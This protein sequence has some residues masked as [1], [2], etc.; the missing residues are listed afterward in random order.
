MKVLMHLK[1]LC[2]WNFGI[3]LQNIYIAYKSDSNLLRNWE[4]HKVWELKVKEGHTLQASAAFKITTIQNFKSRKI[5]WFICLGI[6]QTHQYF[7]KK[8]I[9]LI[10]VEKIWKSIR[11]PKWL[12]MLLF[13]SRIRETSLNLELFTFV[14]IRK[15][16]KK[17]ISWAAGT[18]G[19]P[20]L[21]FGG[22][23]FDCRTFQPQSFFNPKIQAQTFNPRLFNHKLGAKLYIPSMYIMKT[24][25]YTFLFPGRLDHQGSTENFC[26]LM[27]FFF[28]L[29]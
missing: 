18:R 12:A 4:C 29:F 1:Y 15:I 13:L 6:W 9:P 3:S 10:T 27:G 26:N 2:T 11:S 20:F 28:I 5:I 8:K 23:E 22:L 7:L 21:G 19:L 16:V 14:K 17:I 25:S 24:E